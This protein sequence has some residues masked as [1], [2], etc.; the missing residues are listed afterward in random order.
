MAWLGYDYILRWAELIQLREENV[1]LQRRILEV[2][3]NQAFT[4]ER[5]A[6]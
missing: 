4:P 1:D 2:R 6:V 3:E 5:D